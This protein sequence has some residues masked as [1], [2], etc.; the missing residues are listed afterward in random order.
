MHF[1]SAEAVMATTINIISATLKSPGTKTLKMRLPF[2]IIYLLLASHIN[3]QKE[4]YDLISFAPPQG[5]KKEA[6]ENV[7]SYSITNNTTGS[8]CQIGVFKSTI[9]KGSIAEDFESEWQEL[10]IKTYKEV[11]PPETSQVEEMDSWKTQSGTASFVFNNKPAIVMLTTASGY[12]R[13]MSIIILTNSQDYLS[14]I[15]TLL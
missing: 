15:E 4:A 13:C 10:V 9:S 5:W 3:A 1:H 12:N 11:K 14:Q 6:K 7:I 8:W 2:F